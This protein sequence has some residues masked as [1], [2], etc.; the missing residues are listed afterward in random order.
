MKKAKIEMKAAKIMQYGVAC[1]VMPKM[2]AAW[3]PMSY[4]SEPA[5]RQLWRKLK[6]RMK[7]RREKQYRNI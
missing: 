5:K 2:S 4:R 7:A 6:Y 1:L 3:L